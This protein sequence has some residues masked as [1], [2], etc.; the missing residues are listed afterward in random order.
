VLAPGDP[1]PQA[2][3]WTGPRDSASLAELTAEGPALLVFY[4]FDFSST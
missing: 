4:L 1:I 3:V 2:T